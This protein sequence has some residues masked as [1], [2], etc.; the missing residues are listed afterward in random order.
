MAENGFVLGSN[1]G[2][3]VWFPLCFS[4]RAVVAFETRQWPDTDGQ[5][6]KLAGWFDDSCLNALL[7]FL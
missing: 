2:L 6:S 1:P 5:K 7:N 4:H 3:T